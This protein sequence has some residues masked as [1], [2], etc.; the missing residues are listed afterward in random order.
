MRTMRCRLPQRRQ[1]VQP[2]KRPM[3]SPLLCT[4]STKSIFCPAD[5]ARRC[6]QPSKHMCTHRMTRPDLD[7]RLLNLQLR[8]TTWRPRPRR[9][10]TASRTTT[11]APPPRQPQVLTIGH[12][13]VAMALLLILFHCRSLPHVQPPPEYEADSNLVVGAQ[14]RMTTWRPRTRP[15]QVQPCERAVEQWN[16][17][18]PVSN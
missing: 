12:A 15:H 17:C 2:T 4:S 10:A 7:L 3:P 5:H 14:S 1:Q 11:S 13:A 16:P 9:P 6:M 18:F 8:M